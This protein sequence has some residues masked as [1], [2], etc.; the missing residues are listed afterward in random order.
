MKQPTITPSWNKERDKETIH[1]TPCYHHFLP[2]KKTE[3]VMERKG[4]R[5]ERR[6]KTK[7]NKQTNR[8][9]DR[10]TG[11]QAAPKTA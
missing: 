6:K 3:L 5:K 2:R 8:Q 7:T 11:R 10:Q 4:K 9:T 1:K